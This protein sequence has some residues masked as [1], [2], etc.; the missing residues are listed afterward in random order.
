M[1][2]HLFK[3]IWNQKRKNLGILFEILFS[4]MVL[5]AVFTFGFFY[6]RFY[7]QPL[8]FEYKD[9]WAV[10]LNWNDTPG[11]DVETIQQAMVDQ[12]KG[13]AE[14]ERFAFSNE[15]M[16][17]A[18]YINFTGFKTEEKS[19]GAYVFT[20]DDRYFQTMGM[21]LQEGRWF[22][23]EDESAPVLP[24]VVTR[25]FGK[26]MFGTDSPLGKSIIEGD[27]TQRKIIG[28]VD[29][30]RFGG[31]LE[32]RNNSVFLRMATRQPAPRMLLKVKSSAGAAFEAK[33]LKDFQR[34]A[35]GWSIEIKYMEE[36]RRTNIRQRLIPLIAFGIIGLFLVFNV[37]LGLFGVLWQNIGKR[38]EEI[39]VR[40]AMGSTQKEIASQFIGEMTVLATL[41]LL[42]GVFFAVQFPLL[43]VFKVA[44]E[45]YIAAILA[46]MLVIYSL[47]FLCSFFP[48]L[49][50]ARM[51]PAVAL[52]DE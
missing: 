25:S 39:G 26:A 52:R 10:F 14:I 37:A 5:F 42:L 19:E 27:N 15:V 38:R 20:A 41:S 45:V 43:H 46:G 21:H 48:S 28:V 22:E 29:D 40:R 34:L 17:F 4:Y 47:V 35:P 24:A 3:L 6:L 1:I 49:Q 31:D 7:L 16:P 50:A 44:T 30:F 2:R 13:H 32:G 33:L 8:G 11:E 18:N 9:R 36:M 12:L 23:E 51:H